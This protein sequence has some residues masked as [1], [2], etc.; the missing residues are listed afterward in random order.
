MNEHEEDMVDRAIVKG[1]LHQAETDADHAE[2]SA[3]LRRGTTAI[4]VPGKVADEPLLDP[5]SCLY[6][7]MDEAYRINSLVDAEYLRPLAKALASIYGSALRLAA[8]PARLDVAEAIARN[9]VM[10]IDRVEQSLAPPTE[11]QS[12]DAETAQEAS[13]Q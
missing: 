9:T 7:A 13:T 5:M 6:K 12:T 2:M 1:T 3:E 4:D 11:T 8:E 10:T